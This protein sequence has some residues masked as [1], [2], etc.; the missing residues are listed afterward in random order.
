MLPGK[1]HSEATE[2]VNKY[3]TSMA[4]S[5]KSELCMYGVA[6]LTPYIKPKYAVMRGH[7]NII[8]RALRLI[9]IYVGPLG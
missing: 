8:E 3:D 6:R 9:R 1:Y 4:G 5:T 7:A 2:V